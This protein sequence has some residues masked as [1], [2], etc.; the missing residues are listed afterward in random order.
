MIDFDHNATT[1]LDSRVRAA[2]IELLG[3]PS[4]DGNPSSVHGR[5]RAARMVVERARRELAAALEAEPLGVS[6]T[7][8]G[9]EA[10]ALAI[11]GGCRALREAG[12]PCAL[13][14]TKIEHPAVLGASERLGREGIATVFVEVDDRGRLTPAEVAATLAE[15]PEVGLVSL[16]AANHELGNRYDLPAIVAAIRALDRP[17]LVHSDAVQAFGKIPVSFAG[18]GV[19][20]LS[21]SSHKIHG[22]KGVGALVHRPHQVLDP[23]W[24]GGSQERGRRVGTEAVPAIHGFGVAARLV[25]DELDDRRARFARLREQLLAGLR[26]RV[27]DV[28]IHGDPERNLGNTVLASIP[29]CSGE[30][31]LM[32]LDV[33]GVAIS[34][35][36]ACNSGKIGG[37]KVLLALGVDPTLAACTARISLGKDNDAAQIDRLLELLPDIVARTRAHG[38]E[39]LVRS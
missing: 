11:L 37:S 1:P 15:H 31:L 12:R 5:G 38:S 21:V 8:G 25:A 26:E 33:E 32:N 24:I 35:G 13:L 28:I 16:A 22:P 9:T 10:D 39:L 30:L 34:T 2:M 36:S 4:L 3:D 17:V 18:W 19:D 14:T 6:F 20:L 27:P 7:S 23:L 29:G